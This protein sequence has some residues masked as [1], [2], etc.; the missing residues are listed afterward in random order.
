MKKL[1]VAITKTKDGLLI[2]KAGVRDPRKL[3]GSLTYDKNMTRIGKIVD[4][5]GRVDEPYVVIKPESREVLDIVELGLVYYYVE[6][7][8]KVFKGKRKGKKRR[9]KRG[10]R[11]KK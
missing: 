8:K 10:G 3:V 11:R 2:V 4:V 1:G 6:R 5:I 9:D 7:R